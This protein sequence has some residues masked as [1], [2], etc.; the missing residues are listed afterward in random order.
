MILKKGINKMKKILLLFMITLGAISL[1]GCNNTDKISFLNNKNDTIGF[2]ALSSISLLNNLG[3]DSTTVSSLSVN[4]EPQFVKIKNPREITQEQIEEINKYLTIMDQMFSSD[5]P[6]Q[7]VNETS[8]LT[9]YENKMIIT[10][11]DIN[12]NSIVYTMYYN[13]ITDNENEDDDE[14]DET[15]K[16]LVGI[17]IVGE[18][19]YNVTGKEESE[20]GNSEFVFTAF[21]DKDNWVKVKQE[22]DEQESKFKFTV[23]ENGQISSTEMK[24]EEEKNELKFTL[25]T[26]TNT[27]TTKYQFK[28]STEDNQTVIH[29]KVVDENISANI[30]VFV[31]TDSETG[32]VTYTYKYV[33][34][35][36]SFE[37]KGRHE[38]KERGRS[39]EK[40]P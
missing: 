19:E 26:K 25:V 33:E 13:Y 14:Q 7:V 11:K 6:L 15:E 8:D 23:C 4:S 9:E 30:K 36:Q 31:S 3:A 10:T 32:E 5:K 40:R 18:K 38:Y 17:I 2:Q 21:S 24:L 20:N 27:T 37:K 34:T 12:Q 1:L 29:I 22:T 39:E 35:G 28:Q 16:S